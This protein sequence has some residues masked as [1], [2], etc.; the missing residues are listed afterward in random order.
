MPFFLL[1]KKDK[2]H[3]ENPLILLSRKLPKKQQLIDN[4]RI[5][6]KIE[7]LFKNLISNGFLIIPYTSYNQKDANQK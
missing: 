3:P 2:E 7:C 1:M 4:Y 5:R 6:R